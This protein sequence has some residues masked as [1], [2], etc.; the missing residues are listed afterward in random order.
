MAVT[1]GNEAFEFRGLST[2]HKPDNKNIPNGSV[3]LE[4]DTG[5]VFIFEVSSRS[6]LIL[7]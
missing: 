5:K 4:I 3:F 1:I 6:W 2:D 7:E